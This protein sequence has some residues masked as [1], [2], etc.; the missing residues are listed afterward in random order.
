MKEARVRIAALILSDVLTMSAVIFGVA[1]VYKSM[2]GDYFLSNY[3]RLWPLPMIF[4]LLASMSRL[5]HGNI[6]YP[7]VG[8]PRVEEFRRLFYV[9]TFS[10]MVCLV[11]LVLSR[12]HE[13]F[14]RVVLLVSW[15][16]SAFLMPILRQIVRKLMKKL[17]IGQ[18]PALI[19]GGGAAGQKL[20]AE[21]ARGTYYG[22][23]PVGF[24]DD[25]KVPGRL[26][27]LAQAV[28]IGRR[29]RVKTIFVCLPPKVLND[30][31]PK[32]LRHFFHVSVMVDKDGIPISWA[33]PVDISGMA[34]ME[35]SNQLRL[36]GPRIFKT[37]SEIGFAVLC[38]ILASPLFLI[39]AVA[40]KFSGGKGPV[41]YKARRL[42]RYGKPIEVWKFRTMVA[43]ADSR[44]AR[45]LAE[46]PRMAKEWE[47]K[48]KLDNDPRITPLGRYL[49]KTSLDELPQLF[50]VIRGEMAII[51]PR[52]IVEAEKSYYGDK[53]KAFIQVKPGITG[54]WQVSGRSDVDYERRVSLD[55]Y[56]IY[57]WSIWQDFYILLQTVLEVLRCRGAK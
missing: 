43:D 51:G 32:L 49:R 26:G 38:V 11:Y 31:V 39:L 12:H 21:L 29:M 28:A 57:N 20:A 3:L 30:Y 18:M 8:L 14:S 55:M 7:G 25:R 52:P 46:N 34:G 35:F 10:F 27:S 42:G 23:K 41:L 33:Y 24:V 6:V 2:G 13:E 1:A 16:V 19:A 48:F 56:Y 44:L 36:P 22:F 17:D 9:D 15:A 53:Y 37:V 45:L 5:Y 50:N 40:V 54:L 47:A 4:V